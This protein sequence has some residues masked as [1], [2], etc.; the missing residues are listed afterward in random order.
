M[1]DDLNTPILL[2]RMGLVCKMGCSEDLNDSD[3]RIAFY[4]LGELVEQV[5]RDTQTQIEKPLNRGS[6][7]ELCCMGLQQV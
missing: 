4:W 2:E 3:R 1:L 5:Q 7:F 6:T